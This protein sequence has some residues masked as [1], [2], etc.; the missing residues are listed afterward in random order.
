MSGS[1]LGSGG[2]RQAVIRLEVINRPIDDLL[3]DPKNPRQHSRR[4][5]RQIARSI[6]AFGFNVPILVDANLRVIAGH[7]RLLAGRELGL[8]EV[9][10]IRL[11]HLSEGQKR[12]FMVADNRLT[13]ISIWDDKLLAEQLLELSEL[14]LDNSLETTGFEIAEIDQRIESLTLGPELKHD[15]A[16]IIPPT[17]G[18][19]AHHPNRRSLAPRTSPGRLR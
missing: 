12:A 19:A 15:P 5:V 3:L 6:S 2:G 14:D 4:Q 8:R 9:P 10:T 13:E 7:G 16:D 11:E 1:P 18:R 17:R